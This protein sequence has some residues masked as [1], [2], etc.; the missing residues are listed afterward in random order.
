MNDTQKIALVT[1]ANRGIGFETVRRLAEAGVYTLLSG[2][3]YGRAFEAVLQL[4]NQNNHLPVKAIGLDVTDGASIALAV[5]FVAERHG[6]LDILVNNAGILIDEIGLAP[7]QQSE[8]TWRRTFDINLFGVVA[9]TRAFLPLLRLSKA[10]RI[11][12]VSSS[13]ASLTLHSQPGSPIY[14][15]KFAAYDTSKTAL[16]AWTVHLAHELRDTGIKVNAV[17]PGYVKTD[18]NMGLGEIEVGDGAAACVA[19]ALL[20]YTG[21]TGSYVQHGEALPW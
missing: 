21:P 3:D 10:G 12:N 1:G 11:V 7:S 6:R 15:T 5:E 4:Q 19:M 17:D 14:D 16:N 9:V 8:N 13:L 2:R 18:M 20:D